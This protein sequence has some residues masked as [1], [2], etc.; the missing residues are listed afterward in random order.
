MCDS[1]PDCSGEQTSSTVDSAAVT[2][3]SLSTT[4]VSTSTAPP[5]TILFSSMSHNSIL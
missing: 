5:T 1:E 4:Q 3:S 2:A